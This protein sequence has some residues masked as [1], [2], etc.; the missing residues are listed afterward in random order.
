MIR[1]RHFTF[2][3]ALAAILVVPLAM[4]GCEV[5]VSTNGC[6]VGGT[7]HAPGTSFPAPD[8]CNT[9]T[10]DADGSVGCT[11]LACVGGCFDD[12]GPHEVG[13]TWGDDCNQCTCLASG[14]I[15]CTGELCPV[16]CEWE[17]QTYTPGQQFP[18]GDGC[19]T[20]E[21]EPDGIVGC[22]LVACETCTFEGKTYQWGDSFPAG[23]GCNICTCSD[24]GLI[25]CTKLACTCNPQS[26]W[27]RHYVAD[28]PAECQVIDF[29]CQ[30][31]T[32]MFAN[33]CGCGC[34]QDA[35]CPKFFDCQ[36]PNQCDL[37]KIMAECPFSG[38][39]F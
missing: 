15:A 31:N 7:T 27:W 38:I 20:C 34:E 2:P 16:T 32:T 17:G 9:C 19:N 33:A 14:D 25:S 13:E 10:C 37:E 29:A 12:A 18:A 21:C 39:A 23:D 8:G 26:E 11:E 4:M 36:P 22:T 35:S 1:H 30:P 28:S 5:Q 3:A 24:G 6:V